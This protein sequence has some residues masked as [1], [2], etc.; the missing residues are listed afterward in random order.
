MA[1]TLQME[2][3]GL[4]DRAVQIENEQGNGVWP[5]EVLTEY[6]SIMDKAEQIRNQ[7]DARD[8]M[9]AVK[10]FTESPDGNSAVKSGFT[11][12][13]LPGE[14]VI[15]NTAVENGELY[16]LDKEA[17]DRVAILKSAAYVDAFTQHIRAKAIR[18]DGWRAAMTP[19]ALKILQAGD[20]EST[21]FWV[22]VDYRN[23][24][25]KKTA[26]LSAVR[27]NATVITTGSDLVS[28]PTVKYTTDQKYTSGVRFGWNGDA[29][30]ANIAESTN[31]VAGRITIPIHVA[32]AT[33]FLA[34]TSLEDPMFDLLGYISEL[35]AE[36][37]GLG[38]EDGYW[39][40]N[41]IGC[42][43][44]IFTNANA[45][46]AHGTGDGMVVNSGHA[47][48]LTWG[49][50]ATPSTAATKGLLGL[51][52]ALPPQYEMGAKWYA[53]KSTY[54]SIRALTDKDERPLWQTTDAPGLTNYV[55]GLPQTL[56]GYPVEK[57][58]FLPDLAASSLSVVF[59]D[60]RGY[61]IA[62]RTGLSIEVF[63]EVMGLRD[64]VAIY[65]R[66]RTGGAL[67]RPWQLKVL[68]TAA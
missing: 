65:A 36:A 68:K 60:L 14:G 23:D 48:A 21:G 24:L 31:P 9:D 16:G 32:T 49:A 66:K 61:T 27:Q 30:S 50:S 13:A 37:F 64:L 54:S 22:P 62:D 57:S 3:K 29:P 43:E 26:T 19:R 55:R 45:A 42:P 5:A 15:P 38:E 46:I 10:R 11:R 2:L 51:E 20:D 7:I 28:F 53:N 39:N 40:G 58:Q 59:G 34:R 41:G 6:K 4:R 52:A 25:V 1:P 35:F 67:L 17:E 8:R 12:E 33:V 18:G 44:G 63:R 47:T 56:L